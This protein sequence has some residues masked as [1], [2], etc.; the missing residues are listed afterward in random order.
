MPVS[1]LTTN[2]AKKMKNKILAISAAP[3]AKPKNPK[4]PAKIATMK[5][6]TAQYNMIGSPLFQ[7]EPP[8]DCPFE[9]ARQVQHQK[10]A[11]RVPNA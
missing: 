3:A 6:T 4:A 8:S 11:R 5:N 7:G 9:P 1:K 10:Q 2:S